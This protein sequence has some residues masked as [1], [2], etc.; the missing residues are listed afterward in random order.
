MCCHCTL[1]PCKSS[2]L[3]GNGTTSL[4]NIVDVPFAHA[5]TCQDIVFAMDSQV[6]VVWIWTGV[7]FSAALYTA[8]YITKWVYKFF[9][10]VLSFK[11]A[12][13][14]LLNP[15]WEKLN[16]YFTSIDCIHCV[17]RMWVVDTM[18]HIMHHKW[19]KNQMCSHDKRWA[20]G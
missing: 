4:H 14:E 5:R 10:K 8:M 9:C 2:T 11:R 15:V 7:S 16:K 17:L 6:I 13:Y 20:W 18:C 12:S 1:L 3:H 19:N